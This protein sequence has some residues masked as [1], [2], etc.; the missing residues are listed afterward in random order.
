MPSSHPPIGGGLHDKAPPSPWSELADYTLTVKV[1]PK[2]ETGT[3]KFRT[4]A[5]PAD[6]IVVRAVV[7]GAVVTAFILIFWG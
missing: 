4:F 3:W 7:I 2:G 6:V 1:P 5:D